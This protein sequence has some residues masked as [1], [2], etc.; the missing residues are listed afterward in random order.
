MDR[1]PGSLTQGEL[2]AW[3]ANF[4]LSG[5]VNYYNSEIYIMKS[6]KANVKRS[7]LD[8]LD[9]YQFKGTTTI[10]SD[11]FTIIETGGGLELI[12]A[13]IKEDVFLHL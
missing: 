8:D 3:N 9:S 11:G 10:H 6:T 4:S 12:V 1:L 7:V 13:A 5:S 2:T